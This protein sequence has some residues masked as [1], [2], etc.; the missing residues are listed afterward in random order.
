MFYDSRYNSD[1]ESFHIEELLKVFMIVLF[2]NLLHNPE[3]DKQ[4]RN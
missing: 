3:Q 4:F 1:A 2:E